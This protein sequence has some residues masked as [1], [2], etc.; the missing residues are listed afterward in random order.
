MSGE[1]EHAERTQYFKKW[2]LHGDS[3]IGRVIAVMSGKGG[4]G[5]SSL[6]G[7]LAVALARR[8]QRVGIIDADI[9]GP[10]IPQM[11]GV[12]GVPEAVDGVLQPVESSLGVRLMSI[13]LLLSNED[14][15]VIWR[16]PLIT[17]TI[18]RF[19]TDVYWGKLDFLLVDLPPG[20][21]DAPLSVMQSFPLDGVLIVSSPQKVATGVVKKAIRM[22][23]RLQVPVVGLIENMSYIQCT[24]CDELLRVFGPTRGKELAKEHGIPFLGVLP[25]DP[26]L[27]ELTD[28]GAIE[29][30]HS[31][32]LEDLSEKLQAENSTCNAI[33]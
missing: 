13:Q 27:A 22:A 30:Y 20:T 12:E 7:M 14:S 16:A 9:T 1:E 11:F 23:E 6:T 5:K 31:S 17:R 15:P 28:R 25:L 2:P 26:C 32:L 24:H 29:E 8:K 21:G 33:V 19:W 18:K 10:T 4:V 3:E